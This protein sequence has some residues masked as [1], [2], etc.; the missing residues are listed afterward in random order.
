MEA[1]RVS[2]MSSQTVYQGKTVV[3]KRERYVEE[4]GRREECVV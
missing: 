1:K 2:P 4:V 3:K